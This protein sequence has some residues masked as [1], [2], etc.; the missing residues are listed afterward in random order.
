MKLDTFRIY[1]YVITADQAMALYALTT[2]ELVGVARP[3]YETA[4]I[5]QYSFDT[6]PDTESLTAGTRFEWRNMEGTHRG[7]A[8]FNGRDEYVN[9]MTFPDDRGISFPAFFGNTS[10]SFE[11][12]VKFEQFRDYSRVFDFGSGPQRDNVLLANQG[13]SANL[14]FH[15]YPGSDGASS[16]INTGTAQWRNN[17]WQHVVVVIEDMSRFASGAVRASTQAAHYHI[18]IN[19]T[20]VA[21]MTGYLPARVQRIFSYLAK[22]SWDNA[23][24]TG[25]IDSF[26]YYNYAL[27][28]EQVNVRYILPRFPRVRSV[29]L[30]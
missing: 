16:Q 28:A 23:L 25:S 15:V 5:A 29:V 9:L 6:A 11:A 8:H 24:F 14:A 27:S 26:Y 22:S 4:P 17:T 21:N 2:S 12:W 7:V 1:D 18:Y 3:L 30:Q 10:V 20:R 13:A 19:G